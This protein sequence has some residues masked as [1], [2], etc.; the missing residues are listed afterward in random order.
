[1]LWA[2]YLGLP[3]PVGL[4]THP[5]GRQPL[6]TGP[7]EPRLCVGTDLLSCIP[8]PGAFCTWNAGFRSQPRDPVYKILDHLTFKKSNLISK[9]L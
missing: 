4:L 8:Q 2:G 7:L 5:A 9:R 1:M 3:L 6:R